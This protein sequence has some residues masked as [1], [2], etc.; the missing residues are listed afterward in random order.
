MVA[1]VEEGGSKEGRKGSKDEVRK[2]YMQL[3]KSSNGKY[4]QLRKGSKDEI[5]RKGSNEV[6]PPW[7]GL[8]TGQLLT[9]EV[10][11]AL[12]QSKVFL[13]SF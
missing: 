1:V 9:A 10:T 13:E 8:C 12:L 3:R 2:K 11:R 6:G 5:G 7:K 4:F